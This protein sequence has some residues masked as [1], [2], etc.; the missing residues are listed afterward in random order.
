MNVKGMAKKKI[1]Q[2][3]DQYCGNCGFGEWFYDSSNLDF[4][5]KPICLICPYT[6]ERKRIRSERGC[7]RWKPKK[8]EELAITPD[9]YNEKRSIF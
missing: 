6:K 1:T 8:P 9:M 2:Q 7:E 3:T 5:D 4:D